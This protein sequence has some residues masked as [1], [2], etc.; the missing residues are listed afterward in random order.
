MSSYFSSSSS[1]PA[2]SFDCFI[3]DFLDYCL[4]CKDAFFKNRCSDY[5][6]TACPACWPICDLFQRLYQSRGGTVKVI[7]SEDCHLCEEKK[8]LVE[9]GAADYESASHLCGPCHQCFLTYGGHASASA[10]GNSSDTEE[11]PDS[12]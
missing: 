11:Y 4:L 7:L 6:P 12:P 8:I 3:S 5:I 2:K 9:Y 1:S 10:S